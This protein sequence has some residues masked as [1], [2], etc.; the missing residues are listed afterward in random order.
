[1]MHTSRGGRSP[2]AAGMAALLPALAL[3]G[4]LAGCGGASNLSTSNPNPPPPAVREETIPKP[5][6]TEE[7]VIWQPGHWDWINGGYVWEPGEW[8]KRAGHGTLWMDGHWSNED[9]G[10]V[11]KRAHWM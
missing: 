2:R 10:W 9:G 7:P 11:W 4:F 8:V 1:M 5:P 6:V 3:A